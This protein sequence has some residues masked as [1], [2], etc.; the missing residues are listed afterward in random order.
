[1]SYYPNTIAAVRKILQDNFSGLKSEKGLDNLPAH[2]LWMLEK[3]EGM[4]NDPAKAGR[5][6]GYILARMEVFGF[7]TNE[8]SRNLIREDVGSGN[9]L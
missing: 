9:A 8:E 6:M 2:L 5:W 1:M 7:F 4:A 3:I